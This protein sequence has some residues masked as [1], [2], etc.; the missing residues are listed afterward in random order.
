VTGRK[1]ARGAGRVLRATLEYDGSR[2]RGWQAQINARTVQGV[3]YNACHE[4]L[5]KDLRIFGAGRTDAGV[6][7]FAQ[8]AS[9]HDVGPVAPSGLGS[10]REKINDRLPADIHVLDL[11]LAPPGFHARHS[12]LLRL[13][14]YRISRRR[15]AFGKPFVWWVKDHL[16]AKAMAKAAASLVGRHDF[17][18]F[19]ENPAGH[20]ST[21]V[22]VSYSRVEIPKEAPD[23]ILFRIGASHFLWKMV[24][25]VVGTLVEVGTGRLDPAEMKSL[26]A[27]RSRK[28]AAW[29]APPSGLFL[30]HVVYP[31]DPPP[32]D[33]HPL[34]P[35]F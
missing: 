21:L 35:G 18:S 19:C 28:P 17:G 22:E 25:R 11:Q 31:G 5:G 12:A 14:R 2:Y 10:L 7:A 9:L 33:I 4:V 16:D 15:T 23:L 27:G 3:V 34:R 20:D 8:V 26:L 32:S 13:Y 6:H 1:P 24:R 30:E 29:T